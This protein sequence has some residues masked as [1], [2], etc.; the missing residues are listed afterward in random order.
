[1]PVRLVLADDHPIVLDGLEQLFRAHKDFTVVARCQDGAETLRAVRQHRPL[2][3]AGCGRTWDRADMLEAYLPSR[4]ITF[5]TIAE[6]FSFT[7]L[8]LGWVGPCCAALANEWQ[9]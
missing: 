9:P 2:S 4:V 7:L 1:M 3:C 5:D 6:P 8:T